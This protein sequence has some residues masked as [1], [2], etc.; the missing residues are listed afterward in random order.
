MKKNFRK[1][2]QKILLKLGGIK[3]DDVEIGTAIRISEE[4]LI[5]QKYAHLGISYEN[6]S[7]VLPSVY[8]PDEANG[9]TSK[10]N[11]IGK[12]VVRTDLPKKL[13]AFSVEVPNWGDWS[14]GSHDMSWTKEVFQRDFI[15]PQNHCFQI[16]LLNIENGD[17]KTFIVK[18]KVLTKF[19][20]NDIDFE[21][22][23][24]FAI[25]LLQ[26]NIGSADIFTYEATE[27]DYIA[28]EYLDWEIFPP[29]QKDLLLKSLTSK[30]RKHGE[31]LQDKISNRYDVLMQMEPSSFIKGTSGLKNYFGAKFGENLVVFENIEYGNA[32]YILQE[33]WTELSKLSRT[34]LCKIHKDKIVRIIHSNGWEETLKNQI[35]ILKKK[36]DFQAFSK[37]KPSNVQET[38][39]M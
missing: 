20:I 21:V 3:T 35:I 10:I 39:I 31:V 8:L 28:T 25:N 15:A 11:R 19:N 27:Q 2:P 5:L 29:G 17:S 38:S 13:K 33:D 6:G 37:G 32:V 23:L 16:E 7:I 24:L 1:I 14:N 18:F 34:D 22:D 12:E 30:N 36:N 4:E 9:K 26:E